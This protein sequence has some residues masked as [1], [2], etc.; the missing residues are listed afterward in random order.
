MKSVSVSLPSR[1]RVDS[2]SKS[3]NSR[4]RIGIT[5]PGTFSRTSGFSSEPVRGAFLV[6]IELGSIGFLWVDSD[7]AANGLNHK[8]TKRHPGYRIIGP[9]ARSGVAL[10]R[11]A[12]RSRSAAG[13]ERARAVDLRVVGADG[14]DLGPLGGP[15]SGQ[16]VRRGQTR[17]RTPDRPGRVAARPA[18]RRGLPAARCSSAAARGLLGPVRRPRRGRRREPAQGRAGSPCSVRT[19]A[20][21]AATLWA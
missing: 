4:S 19:N 5:W 1:K 11:A 10:A 17:R 21:S 16:R 18:R 6:W 3:S 7:R 20:C 13:H 15:G 9:S 14:G 2:V 8:T 12:A